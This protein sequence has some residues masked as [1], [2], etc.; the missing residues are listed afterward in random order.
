MSLQNVPTEF[1]LV[2]AKWDH[3]LSA[4]V[5]AD[6][7]HLRVICRF[8]QRRTAERLLSVGEPEK[9]QVITR[10]AT[11][12]F[13][14]RVSDPDA[15]GLLLE[16]GAQIRGLRNLHAKMYV[17]GTRRAIVTS[18]NLTEAAL[19]RNHEFGFVAEEPAILAECTA[20]FDALWP[21]AGKDLTPELLAEM[22]A[23]VL[24]ARLEGGRPLD[25][26]HLPDYGARVRDA[27]PYLDLVVPP[28]TS[29]RA[30]VKLLGSSE[31]RVYRTLPVMDEI[32]NAGCH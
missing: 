15:L 11:R 27:D 2:D 17:F 28:G 25:T 30:F 19:L 18:A 1:R 16:A 4:A 29:T 22:K 9:I 26:L 32:C 12:D 8:I 3:E 20:Y 13:C 31:S 14:D 6:R 5:S 21:C 24:K 10:F 23:V 7:T